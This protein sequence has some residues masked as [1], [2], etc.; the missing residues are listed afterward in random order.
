ML[1]IMIDHSFLVTSITSNADTCE[2]FSSAEASLSQPATACGPFHNANKDLAMC[3][4]MF[5]SSRVF[6]DWVF[7]NLVEWFPMLYHDVVVRF[8]SLIK[9]SPNPCRGTWQ[10]HKKGNPSHLT[11][12]DAA[13]IMVQAPSVLSWAVDGRR[14]AMKTLSVPSNKL[15]KTQHIDHRSHE[16]LICRLFLLHFHDPPSRAHTRLPTLSLDLAILFQIPAG[17]PC[18][19]YKEMLQSALRWLT[20]GCWTL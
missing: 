2:N 9:H 14:Y 5:G 12:Q 20:Q 4:R 17:P 11:E 6:H 15:V 1:I 10:I 18:D 16:T 13:G 3:R 7:G 8:V 19:T